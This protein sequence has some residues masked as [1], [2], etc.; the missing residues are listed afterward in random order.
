[1]EV[2]LSSALRFPSAAGAFAASLASLFFTSVDMAA[3]FW[4]IAKG[5]SF[6]ISLAFFKGLRLNPVRT[7][8]CFLA[9]NA[10]WKRGSRGRNEEEGRGG[11]RKRG[12]RGEEA[13]RR[14]PW[15]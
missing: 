15:N 11:R 6:A 3:R 7:E 14:R 5:F 9:R 10:D 13:N 4:A 2:F 12:W 8:P 1:M